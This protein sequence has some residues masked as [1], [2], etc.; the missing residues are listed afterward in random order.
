MLSTMDI[1]STPMVAGPSNSLASRANAASGATVPP[2]LLGGNA[3]CWSGC[4]ASRPLGTD[5]P[6]GTP[7]ASASTRPPLVPSAVV[8]A[9]PKA[10]AAPS[11]KQG[12][13]GWVPSS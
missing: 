3:G 11:A 2:R 8:S 5:G 12:F 13:P 6:P 9:D 10:A 1:C 7:P 4:S